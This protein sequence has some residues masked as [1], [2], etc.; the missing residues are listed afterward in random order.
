MI[1]VAVTGATGNIGT[2]V[3]E[4]LVDREDVSGV[5]GIARRAPADGVEGVRYETADVAVD[6][7]T[8]TLRGCDVLVHCA[9]LFQP[10]RDPA[11]T[12]AANAV[13]SGKVFDAAV[14][15][16]VGAIVHASS[17]GAYAPAP[18]R[19]V[20][21]GWPTDGAS[22]A[23]YAR[24]K[25]YVERIL[26]AV[27]ARD[28]VRVVRM[29]PAFV[30]QRRAATSQRRIF[31]GPFVPGSVLRPGRLPVLPLPAGLAIQAVHAQDVAAA[32]VAAATGE[33]SGAFNVAADDTLDAG[34]VA[35]ALG[36]RA[37][38]VPDRLARAATSLAWHARLVPADPALVDMALQIP[39]LDTGRARSL[40]GWAPTRSARAALHEVAVGMADG[41]GG[42]SAP[43]AP[44]SPAGRVRE[45]AA[46]VGARP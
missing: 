36:S 31:A 38:R 26:D 5:V 43:L 37:L 41:A 8:A 19:F 22:T 25:A 15:A 45:V 29:R 30:L 34:A 4:R 42:G 46:G 40:L 32:F 13:G 21:E 2:T 16:G 18:G 14:R 12:W 27:E 11:T 39:L 44:D 10:T 6:D 17:V 28:V 1:R 33:A 23:A 20:D 24:E 9:W 7:L 3:V 35:E